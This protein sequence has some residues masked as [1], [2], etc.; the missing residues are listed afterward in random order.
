MK[1]IEEALI[2]FHHREGRLPCPADGREVMGNINVGVEGTPTYDALNGYSC[3][4][5]L[6]NAADLTFDLNDGS[7]GI[8]PVKT[9]SLA[10]DYLY[11]GWGRRIS[12]MVLNKLTNSVEFNNVTQGKIHIYTDYVSTTPAVDDAAFVLISHGKSGHG[13]WLGSSVSLGVPARLNRVRNNRRRD[14]FNADDIN[15]TGGI[16]FIPKVL[17]MSKNYYNISDKS[18]SIYDDIVRYKTLWQIK[19]DKANYFH[20]S[21]SRCDYGMIMTS[22]VSMLTS[23]HGMQINSLLTYDNLTGVDDIRNA[24]LFTTGTTMSEAQKRLF[25]RNVYCKKQAGFSGNNIM[26]T[27]FYNQECACSIPNNIISA[28]I[29]TPVSSGF[30]KCILLNYWSGSGA[31]MSYNNNAGTVT[32]LGVDSMNNLLCFDRSE[33]CP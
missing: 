5:V 25:I 17:A 12:Y 10:Q 14:I 32:N 13:A 2:S 27:C 19:N 16:K 23:S 24:I 30:Y 21:S 6:N 9:L 26:M 22:A 20:S 7:S 15:A 18:G 8:V 33:T 31:N 1:Q 28:S 11:D 4:N 29:T 3:S